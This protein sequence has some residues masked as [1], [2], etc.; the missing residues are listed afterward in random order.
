MPFLWLQTPP[1]RS[2]TFSAPP[3]VRP[4]LERERGEIQE[5]E[6]SK[7]PP[8]RLAATNGR[9]RRYWTGLSSLQAAHATL[10]SPASAAQPLDDSVCVSS[11][12]QLKPRPQIALASSY[13]CVVLLIFLR[14]PRRLTRA[15]VR[16]CRLHTM[17]RLLAALM[18]LAVFWSPVLSDE[19]CK[20]VNGDPC[21]C[22][23]NTTT[24][25]LRNIFPSF[26]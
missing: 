2:G 18:L 14:V 20:K 5:R 15:A 11:Q 9:D 12:N 10:S 19:K 16:C 6:N 26:P 22:S 8:L 17:G 23:T 4:P 1:P 7:Q 25:D 3:R 13:A 21:R 24:I